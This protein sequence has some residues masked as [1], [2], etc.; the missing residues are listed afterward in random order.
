MPK[1]IDKAVKGTGSRAI[2]R[3]SPPPA[4]PKFG[5]KNGQIYK[6]SVSDW[7]PDLRLN[8]PEGA[9]TG[10]PGGYVAIAKGAGLQVC[11]T[12]RPPAGRHGIQ[13]MPRFPRVIGSAA[14]SGQPFTDM[15]NHPGYYW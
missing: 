1:K 9:P 13:E 2:D 3:T 10:F 15:L 12:I 5:G 11:G 8:A 14:C 6:D 4:A 7:A